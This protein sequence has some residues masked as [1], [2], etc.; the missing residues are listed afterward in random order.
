MAEREDL[1]QLGL[2]EP[3][4]PSLLPSGV[5]QCR[6]YSTAL[7]P[8]GINKWVFTALLAWWPPGVMLTA[9][10]L[11]VLTQAGASSRLCVALKYD[12][13]AIH[14]YFILLYILHILHSLYSQRLGS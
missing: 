11:V 9:R 5:K 8:D 1:G 7:E 3:L 2:S 6:W 13:L 12:Y 14:V 4:S 10:A